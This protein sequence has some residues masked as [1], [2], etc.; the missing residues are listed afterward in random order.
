MTTDTGQLSDRFTTHVTLQHTDAVGVLFA[1]A[2]MTWAQLGFE[3]LLRAAGHPLETVVFGEIHYPI[4]KLVVEHRRKLVLGTAI[5]VETYV[6]RVG[7]RSVE[8]RSDIT[9]AATGELACFVTRT[10]VAVGQD[11]LPAPVEPWMRALARN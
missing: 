4:V 10:G 5:G 8:V 7:N 2:P 6:E 1:A 3:N 11:S 9:I